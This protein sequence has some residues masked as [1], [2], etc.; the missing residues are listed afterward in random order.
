MRHRDNHMTTFLRS[1]RLEKI[2]LLEHMCISLDMPNA[3]WVI[4]AYIVTW[5]IL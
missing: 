4:V 2:K 1:L 3:A 5:I